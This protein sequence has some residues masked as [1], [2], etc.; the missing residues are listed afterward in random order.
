M[1]KVIKKRHFL[2]WGRV[3]NKLCD[4]KGVKCT[5]KFKDYRGVNLLKSSFIRGRFI[6]DERR[7]LKFNQ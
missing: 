1:S 4:M 3:A 6:E 5:V 7:R 2:R